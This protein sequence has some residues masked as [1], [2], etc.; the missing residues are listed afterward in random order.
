MIA[1]SEEGTAATTSETP[2]RTAVMNGNPRFSAVSTTKYAPIPIA[3]VKT[4]PNLPIA[5]VSG[6][7]TS[8]TSRS[9]AE[10]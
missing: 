3:S 1:G 2:A 10:M 8:L 6:V 4:T 9:R 5:C 7:W